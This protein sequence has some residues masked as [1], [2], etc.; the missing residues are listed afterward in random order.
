MLSFKKKR[1]FK[2]FIYR[3]F[4]LECWKYEPDER[5]NMQDVV[6]TLKAIIFPGQSDTNFDNANEEE[7]ISSEISKSIPK[8]SEEILDVQ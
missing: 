2:I 7:N 8:S 4:Y 1:N 5:P 3:L 6:S